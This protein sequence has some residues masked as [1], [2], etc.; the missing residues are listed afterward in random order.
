MAI[1]MKHVRAAL[2]PEEPDYDEA[3]K[4]GA[5]A[6]PYLETLVQGDD[7]GISAKAA[8]L[9]GIIGTK[10]SKKVLK[11]AAQNSDPIV[12]V[13]A[14][15]AAR[16]LADKDASQI[17]EMLVGDADI[18]VQSRAINSLP[19]EPSASLL[20]RLANIRSRG[21]LEPTIARSLQRIAPSSDD[22]EPQTANGLQMPEAEASMPPFDAALSANGP[23]E[24][25][26]GEEREMPGFGES[27]PEASELDNK[28]AGES[29]SAQPNAPDEGEMPGLDA[30]PRTSHEP[31]DDA[32][33]E[34][35]S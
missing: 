34:M 31:D 29:T 24:D 32:L 7:C 30:S 13:A 2:E 20:D 28:M 27:G 21:D 9:A 8:S 33:T 22:D 11:I 1:K 35:P 5:D 17:L 6:L 12:R 4:M 14:A 16:D 15:A 10:G 26:D 25:Q 19:N 3:A 18:G 23:E